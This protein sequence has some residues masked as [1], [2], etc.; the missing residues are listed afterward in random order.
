VACA[1]DDRARAIEEAADV[2]YHML[3]ALRSVGASLDD[4]RRVL[5]SRRRD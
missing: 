4:V 2:L 5:S 1:D 3:V